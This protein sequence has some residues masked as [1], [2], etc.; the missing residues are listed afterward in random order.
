[1][2][3]STRTVPILQIQQRKI[4]LIS[5]ITYAAYYLGRVNIAT[6]MPDMQVDLD[7]SRSAVGLLSTGFFWAYAAG[8]LIN[9]RLGD[10]ISPRRFV[11]VGMLLSAGLNILFGAASTWALLLVV[12]TIN[13]Y[14][15][16]TGWGPIIRVL[17]NWLTPE[18]RSKVSGVFGS[19]FVAGNA[20]T[21]LLTGWLVTNHGWR[22]AFWVPA[23][24]LA[25]ISVIWYAFAR[26]TPNEGKPS[27]HHP[28]QRES[29][30]SP[31]PFFAG[32]L[33]NLRRLWSVLLAG[34]MLGF[35]LVSLVVWLPTYLVEERGL[36]IG[37]ASLSSSVLPFAGIAGTLLIGWFSGRFLNGKEAGGL[38]IILAGQ[39]LLFLLF[40]LLADSFAAGLLGLILIGGVT[41]GASSLLL[42]AMPLIL[43]T[44]EETSG[45]AGLV[46][47]AFNMGAGLSG[48]IVGAILDV[49][50]W[51][52]VFSVLAGA[53]LISALFLFV[54]KSRTSKRRASLG[55]VE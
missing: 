2:T 37:Q 17:A 18:Q 51:D 43:A 49:R 55:D 13:G 42:T 41:Y 47:F 21:W 25:A 27:A 35:V 50:S 33:I 38:A 31:V 19:C 30:S 44:R 14:F 3:I 24:L 5:W 15:Q 29:N 23:I 11:L 10:R 22:S 45:T 39:A 46:D 9:G 20:F 1:M 28:G 53:S 16:A 8:Q 6:A 36:G 12:W 26:D 32:F 54:T 4:I 7:L 52:L 48:A 34:A 40:P